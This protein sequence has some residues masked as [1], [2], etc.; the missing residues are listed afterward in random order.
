MSERTAPSSSVAAGRV[1]SMPDLAEALDHQRRGRADR[2][3]RG[4]H[5]DARLDR[6][7][8]VVVEDLDDLGVLDADHALRL[9]GV[10]DEQD[11]PRLRVDEVAAGDEADRAAAAVDDDGGA[12]VDVLDLVGDVGEQVVGPRRRA[13]RG[14]S[15]PGTAP[16]A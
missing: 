9:L 4:A 2:V 10:V 16:T 13:A 5:R 7:D 1:G 11:A 15:A 12:V 14:P 6:A 3:E 8:V